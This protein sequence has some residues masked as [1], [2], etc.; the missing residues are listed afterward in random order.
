[1]DMMFLFHAQSPFHRSWDLV[2][3]KSSI[4][5]ARIGPSLGSCIFISFFR[6][7]LINYK[8]RIVRRI[9]DKSSKFDSQKTGMVKKLNK[10]EM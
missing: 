6:V 8:N 10:I 2:W 5:M 7:F 4:M 3:Q 9:N 1:M